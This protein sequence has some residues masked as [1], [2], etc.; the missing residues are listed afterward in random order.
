MMLFPAFSLPRSSMPE[1]DGSASDSVTER[2]A[3]GDHDA[4]IETYRA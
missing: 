2:L 4:V 3:R 1:V